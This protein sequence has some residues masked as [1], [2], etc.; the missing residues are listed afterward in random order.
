MTMLKLGVRNSVLPS[1]PAHTTWLLSSHVF[2][3]KFQYHVRASAHGSQ[4]M[5]S[6]VPFQG[7]HDL[8]K[9]ITHTIIHFFKV[10][11]VHC[12]LCCWVYTCEEKPL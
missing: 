1:A 4:I 9:S 12:S 3:Q 5:L 10:I 7:C 2:L 11:V 8:A 6:G